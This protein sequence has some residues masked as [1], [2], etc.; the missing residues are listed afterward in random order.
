EGRGQDGYWTIKIVGRSPAA[1]GFEV[2]PKHWIV[3]CHLRL[4]QPFPAP[5]TRYARMVAA[6]ILLALIRIM[7]TRLAA[8]SLLPSCADT[9]SYITNSFRPYSSNNG[10]YTQPS[11]RSFNKVLEKMPLRKRKM[12]RFFKKRHTITE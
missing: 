6:F 3:E 12:V 11:Q 4:A 5:G 2:L 1:V 10:I 9:P 8:D 7:L